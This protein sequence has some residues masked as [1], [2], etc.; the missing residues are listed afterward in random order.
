M[1]IWGSVYSI[2]KAIFYLS[3]GDYNA[4]IHLLGGSGGLSKLLNHGDKWGYYMGY[5]G[6]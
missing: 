1:G 4:K 2:P 3:E 6:Y 5:R